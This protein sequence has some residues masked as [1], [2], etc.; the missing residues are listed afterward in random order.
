MT[1]LTRLKDF[2]NLLLHIIILVLVLRH[3]NVHLEDDLRLLSLLEAPYHHL[4]AAS[5]ASFFVAPFL[6]TLPSV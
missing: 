1:L 3:A 2:A 6:S 4:S 5:S